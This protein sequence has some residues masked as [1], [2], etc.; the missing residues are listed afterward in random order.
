MMKIGFSEPWPKA[1]ELLTEGEG[2]SIKPL[3]NYFTPLFEEIDKR[4]EEA[5]GCY[6]R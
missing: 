2:L 3:I 5:E 1:L 6:G 4:L